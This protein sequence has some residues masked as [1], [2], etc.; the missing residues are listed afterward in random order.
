[1][2]WEQLSLISELIQGKE[3]AEQ[4]CAHLSS[5][6]SL[7][8]K[9][10]LVE[11]ILSSYEKALSMLNWGADVAD[12]DIVDGRMMMDSLCSFIGGSPRSKVLDQDS[13]HKDSFKKGKTM[14]RWTKKVKACP[15]TGLE[16]PL[17][18]DYSWRKYGQKDILGSKF[19]RGY[20][21]CT[22]RNVQ[23]C[24]ATKQVQRSDEDPTILEITYRGRHTCTQE[25]HVKKTLPLKRKMGLV[26]NPMQKHQDDE[27]HEQKPLELNPEAFLNLG[28]ELEVK[29]E[30]L[31]AKEDIFQP[32]CFPS[33]SIGSENEGSLLFSETNHFLEI[34][35]SPKFISPATSE[36]NIFCLN[37]QTSESDVTDIVSAPTSVTNSPIADLD[38]FD[39]ESN[40]PFN[41]PEPFSS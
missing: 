7:R 25:S 38:L 41:I 16:G 40:F 12:T 10:L 13:N 6:S 2:K 17:G 33:A 39:F 20:Y 30:D 36:S 37:V 29:T 5:S 19:P 32:F 35:S 31:D 26:E 23:G 14:P 24:L 3:F 4:L 21:R 9:E 8:E 1:M 18:D 28:A 22:H 15:G 34:L 27:P 11:K